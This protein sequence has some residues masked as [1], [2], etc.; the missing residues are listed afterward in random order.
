[1]L[2]AQLLDVKI[3]HMSEIHTVYGQSKNI[4]ASQSHAFT[5]FYNV[6]RK[7]SLAKEARVWIF[8]LNQENSN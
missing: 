5:H 8:N 1:M 3:S 2:A 7:R 6:V 4:M